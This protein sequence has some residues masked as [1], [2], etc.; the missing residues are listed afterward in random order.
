MT[1]GAWGTARGWPKGKYE[2]NDSAKTNVNQIVTLK[3]MHHVVEPTQ[4]P[5]PA[6]YL[7]LP[8]TIPFDIVTAP[9]QLYF[10]W[11]FSTHHE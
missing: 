2:P 7:L 9:F 3:D 11:V 4:K 6:Y 8:L 10:Y 5:K 1:Y